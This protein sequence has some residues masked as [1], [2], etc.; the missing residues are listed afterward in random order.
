MTK[1]RR[2]HSEDDDGFAR[3]EPNR[4][5]VSRL[6]SRQDLV[7]LPRSEHGADV[8]ARIA[9]KLSRHHPDVRACRYGALY[10]L[11][12]PGLARRRKDFPVAFRHTFRHWHARSARGS[13]T[14][15]F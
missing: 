2:R 15:I 10:R 14:D 12:F 1:F 4:E 13:R 3:P 9:A 6:R 7:A 8:R 11:W 5:L